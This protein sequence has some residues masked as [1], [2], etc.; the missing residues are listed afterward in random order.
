MHG[1][2]ARVTDDLVV[3]VHVGR[4]EVDEDVDDEHDVDGEVDD[5][6]WV[7]VAVILVARAARGRPGPPAP[8]LLVEEEGGDVRREDGRVDDED[9]DEPVPHRLEGRVVQDGEAVHAGRLQLVLR[10]HVRSQ[11][12]HLQ[13]RMA[14]ETGRET[15]RRDWQ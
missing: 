11:R 3:L 6:E 13:E 8:V 2:L 1:D 15:C 12:Q 9:E 14:L 4:A 10:Q 5:G 7:V